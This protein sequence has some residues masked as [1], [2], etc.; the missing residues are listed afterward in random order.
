MAI[1]V[2]ALAILAAVG[3]LQGTQNEARASQPT[4]E[5]EFPFEREGTVTEHGPDICMTGINYELHSPD[6]K[7]AVSLAASSQA[8]KELLEKHPKTA[9]GFVSKAR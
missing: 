1:G 3:I 5:K 4:T 6:D 9:V 8:D 7:T 2:A